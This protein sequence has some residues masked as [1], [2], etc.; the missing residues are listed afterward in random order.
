MIFRHWIDC[1]ATCIILQP[2]AHSLTAQPAC[3]KKH[4][5]MHTILTPTSYLST[6][7]NTHTQDPARPPAPAVLHRHLRSGLHGP[8]PAPERARSEVRVCFLCVRCSALSLS[9]LPT[10]LTLPHTNLFDC[11]HPHSSS[12]SHLHAP[13]RFFHPSAPSP[14]TPQQRTPSSRGPSPLTIPGSTKAA[15]STGL[16]IAKGGADAFPPSR[17]SVRPPVGG[18][19]TPP[20]DVSHKPTHSVSS[21]DAGHQQQDVPAFRLQPGG[22]RRGGN[23]Q[24]SAPLPVM[25]LTDVHPS[26]GPGSKMA[27]QLL[28]PHMEDISSA[29]GYGACDYVHECV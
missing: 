23:L 11:E 18:R 27:E 14:A 5:V 8:V 17:P 16:V 6:H 20:K 7:T 15:P 28:G 26:M 29:L 24:R 25:E 9:C 2:G 1:N 4:L 10:P 21:W 3:F 13:C 12:N 19:G 22:G